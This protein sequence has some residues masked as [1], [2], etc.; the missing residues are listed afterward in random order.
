MSLD[1]VLIMVQLDVVGVVRGGGERK[2]DGGHLL[3]VVSYKLVAEL[4][5]Q[6]RNEFVFVLSFLFAA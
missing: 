1:L 4:A 2:A 6:V 5:H 3:T